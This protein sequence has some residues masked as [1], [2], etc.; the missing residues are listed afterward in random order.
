MSETIV[1]KKG[2][3]IPIS[4]VAE[5]RLSKTVNSDIVAV[6][7]ANFK[8]LLPRLLVKEG[9][10]VLAGSP[11]MQDKKNPDII[12]SS[13]VS[14]VVKEIVRGEKRKLLA[15]L[16]QRDVEQKS[17]DFGV[18]K[19][20]DLSADE[21]K[22]A[23]LGSGL[24][25]FIVQRP[26]GILA[27]PQTEAKAIFVSAI[28]TAPLAADPEYA[29]ATEVNAIQTGIDA[30]AKLSKGGVHLSLDAEVKNSV[31]DRIKGATKHYFK[32]K[33]PKGCVGIQI[34]HISPIRK[35][36]TVWT[37]SLQGLA[38]IGKLFA[39]GVCDMS[40][41]VAVSGPMAIEPAYISCVPGTAMSSLKPFYGSNTDIVRI[42]SGDVM[43]GKTVGEQGYLGFFDNTVTLIKEGTEKELLGWARPFRYKQFSSDHTYFKWCL[44]WLTPKRTF[45]MD[46]NLHGGPRA[47][48]MS[49]GY[50]A[51][52]LPMDIYP[53]YLV[54]ACLAGNIEKME[55]F[56]IYEVLPEDL[57]VC[58]FAD[59][60][61]NSIQDII[62]QGI[63]LMLKEM[64]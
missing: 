14:G 22:S 7:P 51:H 46:T 2:L 15:V 13:P 37:I 34:S 17:V 48:V 59:P 10:C 26:Y 57:A 8:T 23:I 44:G 50:Y 12:I 33:Y 31:F 62:A 27:D 42:V 43:C 32:G 39:K 20:E 5:K 25:P 6:Q 47:F 45:D 40:R 11:V 58:E 55:Q 3:N 64:A 30:L 21:I 35:D 36:E 56:G 16:I 53:L 41:K 9:D 52:Y 60:S 29:F 63:D 4:G 18:R 49:D 61:K 24:W 54:K 1:L 38:A 19:V 28:E